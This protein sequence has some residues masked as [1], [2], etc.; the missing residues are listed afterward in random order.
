MK[1]HSFIQKYFGLFFA[2]GMALG[3]IFPGRFISVADRTM[4]IL[5]TVMTLT[6]ISIDLQA[7]AANLKK[8]HNIGAVVIISKVVLPFLIYRLSLPLGQDI[9]IGVLLLCLTPFAG[10]SP[11]LTQIVGGDTEFIMLSQVVLTLLAPFYMPFLMMLY[12][13]AA[14][15]ID[16]FAMMKSLL[17]L[18]IVPFTL[19]LVLKPL[20]RRLIERTRG[21]FGA[22]NILLISLLLTGLL[23]LAADDIK[24][25]PAVALPMTGIVFIL[26]IIMVLT[27]WFCFFFLDRSKRIGLAVGNVYMNIGLTAVV[28]AGFFSSEVIM[29]VMLYE[30]P[31]NLL[32]ALIGR[33]R[34]FNPEPSR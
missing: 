11:T 28:A 4:L 2:A 7:V 12:A 31:A 25:N 21:Y 22:V 16:P 3:F 32:P 29:F 23:A 1:W 27:G 33:I 19:S 24:A 18:I 34:F 30:L 13:G 6:F 8:F 10:V 26:G 20:L 15:E 14:V 17:F 9:S 5:G